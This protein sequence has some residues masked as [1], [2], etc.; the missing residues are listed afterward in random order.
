[1]NCFTSRVVAV[2][3]PQH[4]IF[5][6]SVGLQGVGNGSPVV[7]ANQ[8]DSKNYVVLTHNIQ[9]ENSDE[10]SQVYGQVTVLQT[11]NGH[12]IWTESELSRDEIPRGYG[13]PGS[14]RNPATGKYIGGME[15]NNDVVVWASSDDAGK[16]RLGSTFVFQLPT[17]FQDSNSD[18]VS[19][20]ES[21]VLKKVRWNSITKPVFSANG[22][23]MYI[24]VTGS[25]LRGWLGDTRFDATANWATDLVPTSSNLWDRK[26]FE[27]LQSILFERN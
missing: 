11:S 6:E 27:Y 22:T 9:D 15:N 3:I 23:N 17:N 25:E 19:A 12:V 18:Q 10:T 1:M 7:I 8:K 26:Y 5:W 2:S 21:Q 4:T 14:S 24:G 13:P 20:L 16:G